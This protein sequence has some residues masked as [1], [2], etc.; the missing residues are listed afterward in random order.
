MAKVMNPLGRISSLGV[1]IRQ[2]GLLP[3]LLSLGIALLNR[4][5]SYR[6]FRVM[7]LARV[8]ADRMTLQPGAGFECREVHPRELATYVQDPRYHL[9]DD[10]LQKSAE[11]GDVCLATFTAG[12]VLAAYCFFALLPTDI[13][14]EFRFHFPE[15]RIY[16]YKAFTHPDWRGRGLNSLSL[17]AAARRFADDDRARAGFVALVQSNN[18]PSIRSF[19]KSG[20]TATQTFRILGTGSRSLVTGAGSLARSGY[21]VERVNPSRS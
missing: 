2:Y 16:V 15:D 5:V 13:D 18:F 10:F 17:A 12:G 1:D 8:V 11:Q 4:L 7:E 20:F 6:V 21:A 3:A 9:S 14:P 19:S